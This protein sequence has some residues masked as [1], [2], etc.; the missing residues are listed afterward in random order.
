MKTGLISRRQI[1]QGA[2]TLGL[3]AAMEPLVPSYA[4][5]SADGER[6]TVTG[7]ERRYD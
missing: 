7:A 6:A 2:G 3:L 5:T 4:Q 1:L